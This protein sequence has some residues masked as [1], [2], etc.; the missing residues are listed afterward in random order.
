MDDLTG[1]HSVRIC[2]EQHTDLINLINTSIAIRV[3]FV[4]VTKLISLWLIHTITLKNKNKNKIIII[5][6]IIIIIMRIQVSLA[7][8]SGVT[9]IYSED[10][11][12]RNSHKDLTSQL[13]DLEVVTLVFYVRHPFL[14]DRSRCL[15]R[16]ISSAIPD[17]YGDSY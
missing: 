15:M 11:R 1:T 4:H 13:H 17:A 5:I 10:A 6:I 12:S 2:G 8:E 9:S 7:G 14:R 16:Q 3:I